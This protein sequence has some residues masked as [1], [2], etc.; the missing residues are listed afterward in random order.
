MA[1]WPLLCSSPPMTKLW[2]SRSSTVVEARRTIRRR[3]RDALRRDRVAEVELADLRL[4]L[5]VDQAAAQHG[6][7]E[8]QTDAELLVVDGDLACGPP[9]T[10][11][12][13]SPPARKLAVSPDSATRLGSASERARPCCSSA[14]M[15][16]VGFDPALDHPAD[17]DAKRSRARQHAGDGNWTDG[18]VRRFDIRPAGGHRQL[19]RP[20]DCCR[21]WRAPFLPNTF[22]C[23]PRSR[24]AWRV[25]STNRTSSMTC[26][27]CATCTELMTSGPNCLAI[28]TA[29]S[30][31]GPS[32]ACP[33]S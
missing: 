25:A 21:C 18:P 29:L 5:H 13:Y 12:G 8:G 24:P 1:F 30:T 3:H 32:G 16:T 7:R 33:R 31:V 26:C 20:G 19:R 10:G 9:G 4:D 28:C 14:L 6:W 11:I 17:H 27:G 15:M 2:P 23:T 22:H